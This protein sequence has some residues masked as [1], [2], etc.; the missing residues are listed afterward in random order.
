MSEE[1]L[2]LR[3][4]VVGESS[5]NPRD[6]S[7]YWGRKLVMATSPEQACDISDGARAVLV[8]ATEAI[9]LMEENSRCD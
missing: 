4:Y 2:T 3:L 6:W 9:V 8:E 5:G 7:R 1:Q